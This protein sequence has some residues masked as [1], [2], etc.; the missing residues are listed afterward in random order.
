M[1]GL[2]QKEKISLTQCQQGSVDRL[3]NQAKIATLGPSLPKFLVFIKPKLTNFP[4]VL[5]WIWGGGGW[6]M[7]SISKPGHQ[8][9]SFE[10]NSL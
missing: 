9:N 4:L 6:G 5:Y 2:E 8:V 1:D 3:G 10:I 7:D